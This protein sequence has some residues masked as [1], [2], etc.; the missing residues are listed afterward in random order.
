[1]IRSSWKMALL[2][3]FVAVLMGTVA[4]Q[5]VAGG[6]WWGS[7]PVCSYG[8]CGYGGGWYGGG[9]GGGCSVGCYS[10]C[11][12][13]DWYLGCRPGPVRRLLL[14]P[15]RWYASYGGCGGGCYGR[16]SCCTDTCMTATSCCGASNSYWGDVQ[17]PGPQLMGPA[18]TPPASAPTPAV[19]PAPAGAA[20][21]MP[22]ADGMSPLPPA[23]PGVPT[24][25]QE[26]TQ[27][28][29]GV[30]TIWVPAEAKVT[31]NGLA[32]RSIGSKRQYVSF[33]LT[34]GMSYRYD[35]QAQIV[36]EGQLVEESHTVTLT[37]GQ[38]TTVAFSFDVKAAAIAAN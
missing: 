6:Y 35:I 29:S 27:D 15:Y 10:S 31:I 9:Y 4:S 18:P 32:T 5:A 17:A 1:M 7:A 37:A 19:K 38:R 2:G 20:P 28:T 8:G 21:V 34:P 33:G 24:T 13:P 36:R 12:G 30:L 25:W 26:P 23:V 22:P 11:C 16:G 14:G 3:V